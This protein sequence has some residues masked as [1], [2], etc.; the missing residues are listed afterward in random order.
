MKKFFLSFFLIAFA[1][2]PLLFTSCSDSTSNNGE[3]ITFNAEQKGGSAETATTSAIVFNFSDEV[4]G[5]SAN[6]ISVKNGTGQITVGTLKGAV[7]TYTLALA[8]V[9]KEGTIKVSINKSGIESGEKEIE[10]YKK[11]ESG[12]SEGDTEPLPKDPTDTLKTDLD[13]LGLQYPIMIKYNNG[14][15][16]TITNAFTS[17]VKITADGE[18]VVVNN[19]STSTE[20]N[21]IVSGKTANGSLKIYTTNRFGLYLN[22][23]NITNPS[24]PAINIQNSK[25]ISVNLVEGTKNYLT[26]G[27]NYTENETEDAKGAFFS[28]GQLE[29][30]GTG[31]LEINGNYKHALAVDDY[32]KINNGKLVLTVTSKGGK[33]I[34]CDSIFEMKGGAVEILTSGEASVDNSVS[35]ADTSSA[36]GIKTDGVKILGG[37]LTIKSTGAGGKGINANKNIVISGGNISVTTTGETFGGTSGGGT[38][39]G[40]GGGK[41]G[42][43]GTAAKAIKADGTIT[44]DGGNIRI[45]TIGAGAEGLESKSTLTINDGYL[46]LECYDDCINAATKLTINGGY[47]YANSSNNDGIDVNG[48]GGIEINGGVIVSAGD[49][50]PE[51]GI[52]CDSNPLKINGGIVIG[53]GG[54]TSTPST[55]SSQNSLVYTTTAFG[56]K[57]IHIENSSGK[58]ILT[59]EV[60][61][62]Y[63]SKEVLLFSSPDFANGT[64]TISY[65]GTISGGENVWHGYYTDASWSGGSAESS[66][67][68]VSGK[69]T[70]V[71]SS[72]GFGGR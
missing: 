21:I 10:V 37:T 40:F 71:G 24:N 59:F 36:A 22:G 48:S 28:E 27:S 29:F 31:T 68:I 5:L 41:Q 9:E 2:I 3:G 23:A 34:K 60:P 15:A 14:S 44:I 47:I 43:S 63:N 33:G 72:G 35:P 12:N 51:E 45:S 58:N 50:S 42:S 18:T 65:N 32:V 69:I 8:S 39:G 17:E 66:Q 11:V 38:G 57:T 62:S 70:T 30:F 53:I 52:D 4:T 46:E 6:E 55:A 19:T 54:A 25:K 26:D 56:V 49:V 61:R 16:P 20:Y 64:Y 1:F 67:A 7:K 13:N